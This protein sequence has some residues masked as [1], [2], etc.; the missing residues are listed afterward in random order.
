MRRAWQK[1]TEVLCSLKARIGGLLTRIIHWVVVIFGADAWRRRLY[2][3]DRRISREQADLHRSVLRALTYVMLLV[4]VSLGGLYRYRM[5]RFRAECLRILIQ[6]DLTQSVIGQGVYLEIAKAIQEDVNRLGQSPEAHTPEGIQKILARRDMRT[7]F[8]ERAEA[9]T[10]VVANANNASKQ[11]P[12][13][14]TAGV[15]WADPLTA[16]A[17]PEGIRR[18]DAVG[19]LIHHWQNSAEHNQWRRAVASTLQIQEGL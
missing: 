11:C 14:L 8:V 1:I 18:E 2:L 15:L 6:K 3:A 7:Q 13:R 19:I 5:P 10:V 9:Q 4:A 17:M 12:A 16:V